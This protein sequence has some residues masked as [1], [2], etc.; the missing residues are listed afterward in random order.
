MTRFRG[1]VADLD[2]QFCKEDRFS[3]TAAEQMSSSSPDLAGTAILIP[4]A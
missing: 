1:P 2:E 3:R 4:D